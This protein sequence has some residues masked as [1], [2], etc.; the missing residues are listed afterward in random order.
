MANAIDKNMAEDILEKIGVNMFLKTRTKPPNQINVVLLKIS[1]KQ[2][3]G[4]EPIYAVME[5]GDRGHII[6]VPTP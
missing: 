5:M 2:L 1:F 3:F 6:S 4:D